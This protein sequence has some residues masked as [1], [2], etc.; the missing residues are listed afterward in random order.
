MKLKL[1]PYRI[2]SAS[3]KTEFLGIGLENNESGVGVRLGNQII[4]RID[5][6][7]YLCSVLEELRA[8]SEDVASRTM[9]G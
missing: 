6:L 9:C 7:M 8:I 1:F 4:N 3:E 2:V 5:K